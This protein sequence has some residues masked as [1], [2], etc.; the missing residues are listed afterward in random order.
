MTSN[1]TDAERP[2]D[3]GNP[4][5]EPWPGPFEAPPFARIVPQHFPP[6]FAR[7]LEQH[8]LEIDAIAR[9]P[10]PPTFA[11][12]IAALERA[13]R[14]LQ[15]VACVFFNL[16]G[17]HTNDALQTIEREIAPELARHRNAI[18]MNE[19]L[20]RRIEVLSARQSGLGLEG[21][22]ARVLERY[23]TQFVR[24]GARLGT[25][26]KQRLAEIAERSAS[27]GIQF[28]QNV[29]A[30]ENAYALVLTDEDDLA[31]LPDFLRADAAQAAADRGH[32]GQYVITLARSSIEPFLQFSRRRDLREAAFKAWLARGE[33]GG[34]TDNR[35][36]AAELVALRAERGKLLDFPSFAHFRL[37]D[38]MAGTPQ[39]ALD[40]LRTVWASARAQALLEQDVLQARVR[41]EGGNFTLAPWDWRYYAEER[42]KAEFDLD[43]AAL[44][45]YLQLDHVIEAA[46]DTAGRLFDLA[47]TSRSDIP[48]HHPDVRAWEVTTADGTAI[49]LFLGDYFARPS[50]RS[51]AWMSAYRNQERLD[52]DIRPIIVNVMN[53]SKPPAGEPALLSFDD[54]RTL[55]HEFG[56]ALHGL[57]SDVTYPMIAGTNV[58]RDFVELPSQLFEHW[59]EQPEILRRHAIHHR[60]GEPMPEEM[61]QRLLAAR[62]HNRG[63]A[64]VEYVACALADLELH[65][66][67]TSGGIDL[68][69]F[70]RDFLAAIGMPEAIAMRHRMPHFS[71]L[72]AGDAYAAGYYAY[73]WSEV[74]DADGF[75]AFEEAGDVFD[76]ATAERLREFIYAAGNARDP[77]HAYR[78]FRGRDPDPRA[79]LR[80]RGLAQVP[81]QGES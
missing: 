28:S 17:A 48:V 58:A 66:L 34:R 49:G 40:L 51:G 16:A 20:L 35:A 42:R 5:L 67:D 62:N 69:G 72:F 33:G 39:A 26:A 65:L 31:G 60:T 36:I 80:G 55:F 37:D 59:L 74:L 78:L 8:R 32:A 75:G 57:L 11:N 27:L 41:A 24:S 3:A 12:T 53:F 70:E 10:E 22:Q 71:H 1:S 25:E 18:Y 54:A 30:D 15:R 63:F 77:A 14:T 6:A 79:L 46:F 50:K 9:D 29:L 21:E 4:L 61:V 7:A 38:A 47:F 81:L 52:D 19:A 56:H 76:P 45:S 68:S 64:T 44:K 43:E 2:T 13:G 73:M 23:H